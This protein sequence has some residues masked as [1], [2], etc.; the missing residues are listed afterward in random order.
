ML[1]ASIPVPDPARQAERRRIRR[2]LA[3]DAEPP[4]PANLPPGCPFANR[5]PAAFEP[6]HTILPE[7]VPVHHGGTTRCHLAPTGPNWAANRSSPTFGGVPPG[8][9]ERDRGA[10]GRDQ[11]T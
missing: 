1:I 5:C 11:H 2:S 9:R 10:R 6:C 7:P 4:S 3:V 8:D